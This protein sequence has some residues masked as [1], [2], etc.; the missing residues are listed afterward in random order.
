MIKNIQ[1]I[2]EN[3]SSK[4]IFHKELGHGAMCKV[5]FSYDKK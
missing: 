5:Y 4:F 3:P 1:F 2:E